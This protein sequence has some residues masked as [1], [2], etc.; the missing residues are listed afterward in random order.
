[1]PSTPSFVTIVG[2]K[3]S[4]KTT[5]AAALIAELVRRGLR[6]ASVKSMRHG[7][8]SLEPEGTDTGRHLAAGAEATLAFAADEEAVFARRSAAGPRDRLERWLPPGI[9]WV[10]CEGGVEGIPTERVVLCLA[11][12][13]DLAETLAARKIP[14]GAVIAVS[15]VAAGAR[16]ADPAAPSLPIAVPVLDARD[17]GDLA[18]LA[19]LVTG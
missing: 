5:V 18:R 6:V 12:S 10:V 7:V 19:D 2:L 8:F 13:G 16:A 1:M 15:G 17:P 11:H 3:K 9:D 4:G 14:P